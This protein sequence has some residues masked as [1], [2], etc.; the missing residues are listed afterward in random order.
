MIDVAII[1]GGVAGCYCAYR[2]ATSAEFSQVSLFESSGRLGGRLWSVPMSGGSCGVAELGGMYFCDQQ[3]NVFGLINHL[4]LEKQF[5]DFTRR[6]QFLRTKILSD[7]DYDINRDL[8]PFFLRSEERGKDPGTLLS[9]ALSLILPEIGT[10][11]PFET[12]GTPRNTMNYLRGVSHN[13][14]GLHAWGFWN[15]LAEVLSNEA[16]DLLLSTTGAASTFRNAN[17]LD[18]VWAILAEMADT[19]KWYQLKCGYQ[20]LPNA[21]AAVA[22]KNV[23]FNLAGRLRRLEWRGQYFNL[24]I[25]KEDNRSVEQAKQVVLALPRRPLQLIDFSGTFESTVFYDDLD[26]VLSVDACKLVLEF[27]EQWWPSADKGSEANHPAVVGAAYTDL[28]M[29][30]CYYSPGTI[31]EGPAILTATYADDVSAS[32]WTALTDPT[33]PTL[34]NGRRTQAS[35]PN[36]ASQAMVKSALSQLRLMHPGVEIPAPVDATFFDWSVDPFGAAWHS[37]APF[38]KSWEV[39]PRMRQ[40]RPDLPIFVCGE[41]FSQLQ[42]WTEGAINSAELV[43]ETHLGL[44]RPG[45]IPGD[46]ELEL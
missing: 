39:M 24:E 9:Y 15:L 1:G 33:T 29:S 37:W 12:S 17:A 21:L 14:R 42:G 22:K 41:A 3:K 40:P 6:T 10:Y 11:W 20:T 27:A 25:E 8:V 38:R 36:A 16:Y 7:S 30:Q 18:S 34:S 31:G 23:R 43:L 46:Y 5:I 4:S 13:G 35:P 26:A 28:P 44:E 19:Y 2:L 32:F 45:W